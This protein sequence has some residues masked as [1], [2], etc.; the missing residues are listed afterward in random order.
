[1]YKV[2]W[3]RKQTKFTTNA[4]RLYGVVNL[5]EIIS[6]LATSSSSVGVNVV[7][8]FL[9]VLHSL[10]PDQV[11]VAIPGFAIEQLSCLKLGLERGGVV[12]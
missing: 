6:V 10:S 3:L 12:D 7:K 1:M 8:L 2:S 5:I 11:F 4:L 9:N